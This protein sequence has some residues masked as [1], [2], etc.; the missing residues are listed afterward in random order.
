MATRIGDEGMVLPDAP[1]LMF[2]KA[3]QLSGGLSAHIKTLLKT[4]LN[5]GDDELDD[6]DIPDE[7]RELLR[8]WQDVTTKSRLM[9]KIDY[10]EWVEK[11]VPI[12]FLVSLK[13]IRD[14]LPPRPIVARAEHIVAYPQLIEAYNEWEAHQRTLLE[15]M[16]S[17]FSS[18][19]PSGKMDDAQ[20]VNMHLAFTAAYVFR[21]TRRRIADS[22]RS[23][24]WESPEQVHTALTG[25]DRFNNMNFFGMS[26]ECRYSAF[27]RIT[28][29]DIA[30]AN[31]F[32]GQFFNSDWSAMLNYT[33]EQVRTTAQST[34]KTSAEMRRATRLIGKLH[35]INVELRGRGS[36]VFES[37][38]ISG[39]VR[40]DRRGYK[41]RGIMDAIGR[42]HYD[43]PDAPLK[44]DPEITAE[45]M[46]GVKMRATAPVVDADEPSEVPEGTPL[47][48]DGTPLDQPRRP[49]RL[50]LSKEI[51]ALEDA[52]MD[53]SDESVYEDFRFLVDDYG[54]R[55]LQIGN[56]VPQ[57]MRRYLTGA[58]HQSV[59]DLAEVV[60]L[61]P[62]LV[63]LGNPLPDDLKENDEVKH[64]SY[65]GMS[66][67]LALGAR[68]KGKA[69]AHYE[70]GGSEASN[71]KRHII[72]LTRDKGS[73]S[74]AH[75]F[76]HALDFTLSELCDLRRAIS[77]YRDKT[78]ARITGRAAG[79]GV[80]TVSEA[81]SVFWG[82]ATNRHIQKHEP[83]P[84]KDRVR[85]VAREMLKPEHRG[86]AQ[87]IDMVMGIGEVMR[88]IYAHELSPDELLLRHS[89]N[90]SS[91]LVSGIEDCEAVLTSFAMDHYDATTS[92]A[93]T[94][95]LYA[96][97]IWSGADK[98]T[99][100]YIRDIAATDLVAVIP[101]VE[102][103]VKAVASKRIEEATGRAPHSDTIDKITRIVSE[104]FRAT[105]YASK[106]VLRAN[107]HNR[108][109]HT[110]EGNRLVMNGFDKLDEE[111]NQEEG[112]VNPRKE[113]M[114]RES[115]LMALTAAYIHRPPEELDRE[116]FRNEVVHL[117]MMASSME[118]FYD[119]MTQELV[120]PT[121]HSMESTLAQAP[122]S[123]DPNVVDSAS[124]QSIFR[125]LGR[126]RILKDAGDLA[127]GIE[128]IQSHLDSSGMEIP[129]NRLAIHP[130]MMARLHTDLSHRLDY[131]LATFFEAEKG[132]MKAV[133]ID[134]D[135]GDKMHPALASTQAHEAMESPEM[136]AKAF[137]EAVGHHSDLPA[138]H[139]HDLVGI[140]VISKA[141]RARLPEVLEAPTPATQFAAFVK[142]A[143]DIRNDYVI[144]CYKATPS[145]G[146]NNN[147][148]PLDPEVQAFIAPYQTALYQH[149]ESL[150]KED[151]NHY[152]SPY[153]ESGDVEDRHKNA[154]LR[155][156]GES[157]GQVRRCL[158]DVRPSRRSAEAENIRKATQA[159][160]LLV[161][162]IVER[163]FHHGG[164][165]H[166]SVLTRKDEVDSSNDPARYLEG[167]E[168]LAVASDDLAPAF[169]Y[170]TPDE[171][172]AAL[173]KVFGEESVP[174]PDSM[175]N[176]Y[177]E[178]LVAFNNYGHLMSQRLN[179]PFDDWCQQHFSM[180]SGSLHTRE[181]SADE[182]NILKALRNEYRSGLASGIDQ[183]ETSRLV[184]ASAAYEGRDFGRN[185]YLNGNKLKYWG[186]PVELFARS[187]ETFTN[188]T[189]QNLGRESNY[190][191]TVADAERQDRQMDYHEGLVVRD[192]ILRGDRRHAEAVEA[193]MFTGYS[194]DYSL[195]YPA[196]EER[197]EMERAFAPLMK[198]LEAGLSQR[199]PEA[200]KLHEHNLANGVYDHDKKKVDLLRRGLSDS[201]LESDSAPGETT[202]PNV[203]VYD[204]H[205][206]GAGD[207]DVKHDTPSSTVTAEAVAAPTPES[208]E[209]S[210]RDDQETAPAATQANDGHGQSHEKPAD[211]PLAAGAERTNDVND[212]PLSVPPAL[213]EAMSDMG[214][215]EVSSPVS[216]HD[217]GQDSSSEAERDAEG[218]KTRLNK[219][220]PS[221]KPPA[222]GTYTFN[223]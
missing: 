203:H 30:M 98:Y 17:A 211:E 99:P 89:I 146:W 215:E 173:V 199:F 77:G 159:T 51:A 196:R 96:V 59:N 73:G 166:G 164:S 24:D 177:E 148:E 145:G 155:S 13:S 212:V 122:A 62:T 210:R 45:S 19:S 41:F 67:G 167:L 18:K 140:Y 80:E 220:D 102:Q 76:G 111:R 92:D 170:M 139:L 119:T 174:T 133:G 114:L 74:L 103:M 160:N 5:L 162:R 9:D 54:F 8:E 108:F 120:S 149:L 20:Y 38:M 205:V 69:S 198:S 3:M 11:G 63:A 44:I 112:N 21:N 14:S 182:R 209:A 194:T 169:A 97:G 70:P 16:V 158:E 101:K 75:E 214:D 171:R 152:D 180:L 178:G 22:Y 104:H 115:R 156:V 185:S 134:P 71:T 116:A 12:P 47:D 86:N 4:S 192:L 125:A 147:S 95:Q 10:K 175:S 2:D 79:T 213:K 221:T 195:A 127:N 42:R 81:W 222:S 83:M 78:V 130:R 153:D 124:P 217:K 183:Y 1:K 218:E 66:L 117:G 179:P 39:Q 64:E 27:E 206:D 106:L 216:E 126:L 72:N 55:G 201:S 50:D 46:L 110:A 90:F 34:W 142:A 40:S 43:Q 84:N 60:Q 68:G 23:E 137:K 129:A 123:I 7:H 135:A 28:P 93:G 188:D 193:R 109:W 100:E 132:V 29:D 187:F 144:P 87:Y 105:V 49:V 207:R 204:A 107:E 208:S 190:L 36:S 37:A 31:R 157:F 131:T 94:A 25:L 33:I 168:K 223:F 219:P 202:E 143:K 61:P 58:I 121:P 82:L 52:D 35:D 176:L 65:P 191:V 6:N 32:F 197:L 141:V 189:L 172:C 181:L 150:H 113:V 184:R 57:K 91:V 26:D 151:R 88:Q 161:G 48:V 138:T 154:S 186:T 136:M 85:D 128:A 118:H 56:Y 53:D 15:E 165:D 200:V 163:S